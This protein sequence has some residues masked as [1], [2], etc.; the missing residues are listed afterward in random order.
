MGVLSR[1]SVIRDISLL[2]WKSYCGWTAKYL[3]TT[4]SNFYIMNTTDEMTTQL[5][6]ENIKHN[7]HKMHNQNIQA[8]RS[9][10]VIP[11]SDILSIIFQ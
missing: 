10:H 11:V 1:G 4:W 2:K 9:M 8:E 6:Y 3:K 7:I 5:C